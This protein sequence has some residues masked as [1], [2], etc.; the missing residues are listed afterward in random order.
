MVK[1]MKASIGTM[2]E[3]VYVDGE[4]FQLHVNKKGV[5]SIKP[6]SQRGRRLLAKLTG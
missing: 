1:V 2:N 5:L 3:T 4:A 6:F